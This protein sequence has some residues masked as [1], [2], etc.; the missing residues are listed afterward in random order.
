[1]VTADGLRLVAEHHR[2]PRPRARIAL[3][4][5]FAEH[6]GRYQ[7]L[8]NELLAAGY[9]C[10]TFDL[11]GHGESG[12]PRGHVSSFA[13]YRDDLRLFLETVTTAGTG[14]P[15]PTVLLAHSLGGLIAL[16][17]LLHRPAPV[18][19]LIL[20]SPFLAPAFRLPRPV[21]AAVRWSSRL[22][23]RLRIPAG[24][25]PDQLS[26]DPAVV[27]AYRDDPLVFG[28]VTAGWLTAALETQQEVFR[29][30]GEI[31][32]PSLFLIGDADAIADPRR[33][34]CAFERLGSADKTLRTYGGF[35]HEV[36][37]EVGRC[38]V[39]RELLAWLA[40]R[41]P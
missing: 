24:L 12:G 4:H 9:A 20:S 38:Q 32:L 22:L 25:D 2:P 27:A 18:E 37:N 8:V 21:T 3:V 13:L 36:L 34:R 26:H 40:E 33:T 30:A 23:P 17:F 41:F 11:R 7:V 15:V 31:T 19:A 16:D 10:H 14:S 29:R 35:R 28:S 5:G 39:V 6:Q 1:M